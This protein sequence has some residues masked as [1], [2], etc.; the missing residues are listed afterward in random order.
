MEI[1]VGSLPYQALLW[2]KLARLPF[3]GKRP[4]RRNAVSAHVHYLGK[5]LPGRENQP[6]RPN[7]GAMLRSDS[8]AAFLKV[9]LAD[10]RSLP[11]YK[12]RLAAEPRYPTS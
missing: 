3:R 2:P 7:L 12:A 4:G 9:S 11:R 6:A 5:L 8:D 10:Q 1:R